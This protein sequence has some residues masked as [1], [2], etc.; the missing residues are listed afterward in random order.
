VNYALPL[1]R[2]LLRDRARE[3]V[4]YLRFIHAAV[5]RDA[6]LTA[7]GGVRLVL[8]KS[9]THTLKA[10]LYLLLYSTVE[11]TM[12]QLLK[13]VHGAIRRSGASA[14]ALHPDLFLHMMRRFQEIQTELTTTNTTQPIAASIVQAWL[15]D[16]DNAVERNRNYLFSGNLD[17]R[18]IHGV[19]RK[20]GMVPTNQAKPSPTHTH[21]SLQKAKDERNALAHGSK[22]F[23]DLGQTL[24]ASSLSSEARSLFR[25]LS[26]I[27]TTASDYIEKQ[28]FLKSLPPTA[29]VPPLPPA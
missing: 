13:E 29:H 6:V 23:G 28:R 21:A 26:C 8:K 3:V 22:S 10:N 12:S 16:Y 17:G 2:A 14:D 15:S 4:A 11:A 27:T 7:Y 24:G 9:L 19:L 18:S 20:Y 25:T 1:T 5:E